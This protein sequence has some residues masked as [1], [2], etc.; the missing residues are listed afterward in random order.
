VQ[1]SERT[2]DTLDNVELSE[3]LRYTVHIGLLPG[4]LIDDGHPATLL[5]GMS[6]KPRS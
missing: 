5:P 1:G 4:S 2:A 3:R 6:S